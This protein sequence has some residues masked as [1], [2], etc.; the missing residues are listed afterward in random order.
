VFFPSTE[1]LFVENFEPYRNIIQPIVRGESINTIEYRAFVSYENNEYYK[2]INLFN[3]VKNP[4]KSSIL[5][6]KSMCYLATNNSSEAIK[7]LLP[8]ATNKNL[9]ASEIGFKEKANWYLA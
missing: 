7:I 8:I 2:A 6:Y 4:S 9:K 3:S 5:F 1:D